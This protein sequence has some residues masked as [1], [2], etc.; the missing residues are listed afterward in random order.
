MLI[1]DVGHALEALQDAYN[2]YIGTI[3]QHYQVGRKVSFLVNCADEDEQPDI[4]KVFGTIASVSAYVTWP[5]QFN[6]FL[7]IDLDPE[8]IPLESPV[9]NPDG[10]AVMINIMKLEYEITLE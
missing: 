5:D 1:A 10:K 2:E 3:H 6:T 4:R 7:R 8:F 9:S